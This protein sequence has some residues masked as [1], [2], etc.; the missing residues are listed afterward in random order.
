MIR[1]KDRDRGLVLVGVYLAGFAMAGVENLES[2]LSPRFRLVDWVDGGVVVKWDVSGLGRTELVVVEMVD[3][4]VGNKRIK[5][6]SSQVTTTL[7]YAET[8]QTHLS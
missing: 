8:W 5:L 1:I 6:A 2:R 4:A 7:R 3:V